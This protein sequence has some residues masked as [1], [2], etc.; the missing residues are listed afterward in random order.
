MMNHSIF[1]RHCLIFILAIFLPLFLFSQNSKNKKPKLVIGLVIDQMRWDYLYRYE[2]KYSKNGFKRLMNDGYS[3]ENTQIP[4]VPTYT[5]P[6]HT[7]IYTGSVPALHGIIANNWFDKSIEKSVYC[8]DDEKYTS[9]GDTTA[10]GKMSPSRML[11]T[12]ICD[13]LKLATNFKS[14]TIGISLKDRGS[15][16]P[17]GHSADGAYWF[18]GESGKWI[19]SSFYR[20][21]L[22]QWVIEANQKLAVDAKHYENWKT[23][24][25]L[26]KYHE[27]TED[28]VVWE[29]P[30]KNESQPIFEHNIK[31]LLEK[32]S[33]ILKS[34]PFGNKMTLDFAKDAIIAESL[35]KNNYTDFLAVS[36][37]STDYIGHQF[38]TN[39]IEIE[40][41]YL[42]LDKEIESFLSFLD[43]KIGK[44]NYLL[45]LSADHGAAHNAT[46]LNTKKIPSGNLIYESFNKKVRDFIIQEFKD[47]TILYGIA[48]QQIYLNHKSILKNNLM[49]DKVKSKISTYLMSLQ[50]I[51]DVVDLENAGSSH[52]QEYLKSLVINGY[53]AQRSGDL[54]FLMNPAWMED[55]TKGTTHGTAYKYD[56]HIPL[57]WYGW[58]IKR[59]KDYSLVSMTDI[60]ATLASMLQ[61]QEPSGCIGKPIEGV[62]KH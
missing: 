4:Y 43:K 13:E 1:N 60:A 59:G 7:C 26:E 40:D 3:C 20:S 27:S 34:L 47:S 6:G 11:T 28:N 62:L 14:K 55:F 36:L 16:L 52:L 19:T 21:N 46:F 12:S 41:T 5:A 18:S 31:S 30:Y 15:I 2:S 23:I 61:I 32:N 10:A 35:G 8:T 29:S 53:N 17:A 24:M 57:I 48:N 42:Q 51:V 38:G 33:E 37:S 49:V 39:S 9:V 54:Y 22:P 56:T 25:S 50:G 58:G 45:F 44:G